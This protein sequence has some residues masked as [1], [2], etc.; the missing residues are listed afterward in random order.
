MTHLNSAFDKLARGRGRFCSVLWK[1]SGFCYRL[2]DAVCAPE[3][4]AL[5][6]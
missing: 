6:A 4:P 3:A 1:K 5:A 2:L